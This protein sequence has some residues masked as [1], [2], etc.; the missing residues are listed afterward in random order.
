M[1]PRI[2]PT[3]S[4]LVTARPRLC[5][6]ATS[7]GP[8]GRTC[9]S[10]GVTL[11]GARTGATGRVRSTPRVAGASATK[12]MVQRR[13]AGDEHQRRVG[14]ERIEREGAR[15]SRAAIG[16]DDLFQVGA[17]QRRSRHPWRPAHPPGAAAPRP[18]SRPGTRRRPGPGRAPRRRGRPRRPR[19]TGSRRPSPS[20]ARASRRRR[21]RRRAWRCAP[22]RR[23]RPR[24]ARPG[25]RPLARRHRA[26]PS[27]SGERR[28][29]I[30][31]R[32][33]RTPV[34]TRRGSVRRRTFPDGVRGMASTSTTW[35]T[36]L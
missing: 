34:P 28:T 31:P 30:S 32:P 33:R 16:G 3:R 15:R 12:P 17:Q 25:D 14:D 35:C 10:S 20:A 11:P 21:P 29:S 2:T 7:S 26:A 24:R 13:R 6:A 9:P 19:P 23:A 18:A 5:H 4:A 1:R 27:C 22:C 36:R 8:S